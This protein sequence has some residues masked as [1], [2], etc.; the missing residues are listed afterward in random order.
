MPPRAPSYQAE[1]GSARV[2]A[3]SRHHRRRTHD[4]PL[5]RQRHHRVFIGL[6]ILAAPYFTPTIVAAIRHQQIA[7]VAV[8]NFFFGWTFVG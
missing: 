4:H 3:S 7:S 8:V 2:A 5:N 6:L 1:A